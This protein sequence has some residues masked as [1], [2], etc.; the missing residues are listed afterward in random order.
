[1]ISMILGC[2]LLI[3][4][5]SSLFF[6]F[7]EN[8]NI[9]INRLLILCFL[10]LCFLQAQ[11]ILKKFDAIVLPM[12]ILF[13]FFIFLRL[14][15]VVVKDTFFCT[16][17]TMFSW[18]S[19]YPIEYIFCCILS[20]GDDFLYYWTAFVFPCIQVLFSIVFIIINNVAKRYMI[21]FDSKNKHFL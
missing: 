16:I 21:A 3:Y 17:L 19:F 13:V 4:L 10:I 6:D 8:A 5:I 2:N 14:I 9:I 18:C 11:Y 1:M 12:L 20:V 7:S 15:T